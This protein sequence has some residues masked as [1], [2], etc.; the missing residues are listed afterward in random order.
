MIAPTA[1]T[2]NYQL[3]LLATLVFIACGRINHRIIASGC[4]AVYLV[5]NLVL[6]SFASTWSMVGWGALLFAAW[7]MWPPTRGPRWL[8]AAL[9]LLLASHFVAIVGSLWWGSGNWALTAGVA[10]W[11]GPALILYMLRPS[12]QVFTWL[13]PVLYI[14]AGLIIYHGFTA[15]REHSG[16][17]IPGAAPTGLANNSNLGA[18]FLVLGLIYIL[19]SRHKWAAAPLFMALLFTGSRWGLVIGLTG[20][21]LMSI[22]NRIDGRTLALGVV[23]LFVAFF[24]IAMM[25]PYGYR[26]VGYES[27][28]SVVHN[29]NGHLGE[30]LAIPHI[31][32]FLP[33][34]VAE[35]PGLHNVPLRMAVENGIVAAGLWV[36]IS[37]WALTRQV[38]STA[39]W[40]LLTLVLLSMLD[41]YSWMGHLG[42][43]W[44]LLIAVLAQKQPAPVA[45]ED[46][47]I[48]REQQ[49]G[50]EPRGVPAK[51]SVNYKQRSEQYHAADE[52]VPL[53]RGRH[54]PDLVGKKQPQD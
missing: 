13:I 40:L 1:L 47:Y 29:L 4:I 16:H 22:A 51:Q 53:Y 8:F 48:R 42:A 11:M 6:P 38:G 9:C 35:H 43:F 30:R 3:R 10:L 39:W 46:N 28:E 23:G 19:S 37:V 36:V 17:L 52:P 49:Y 14:H 7:A 27:F 2:Q 26:V 5:S 50:S 41:Y 54:T 25:T 24:I 20:I 31:P 33:S 45:K 32:S 34:G 15:V 12:L 18:G 21:L 44:W